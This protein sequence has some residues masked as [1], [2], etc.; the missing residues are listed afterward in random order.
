AQ[1]VLLDGRPVARGVW[2]L[3]SL[4]HPPRIRLGPGG[5]EFSLAEVVREANGVQ[6]P[7]IRLTRVGNWPY[8]EYLLFGRPVVTVG[9]DLGCMAWFRGTAGRAAF[10]VAGDR[11]WGVRVADGAEY[12]LDSGHPFRLPDGLI[13]IG[14]ASDADFLG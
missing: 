4:P 11:G 2:T 3:C 14:L 12:P 8:H 10:V 7:C 6:V 1:G 5:V 13:T 9:S